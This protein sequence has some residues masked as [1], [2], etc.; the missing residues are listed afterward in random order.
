MIRIPFF[1]PNEAIIFPMV[2]EAL[3]SPDGLLCAGG[4][5]TTDNLL[6]AYQLGIFP[7]FA[8]DEPVL[9]WCPSERAIFYCD[10]INISKSMRKRL[11]K[12]DFRVTFDHAFIEVIN[13]CAAITK[14]RQDTWITDEMKVA[15]NLLYRQG[16]A[17]SVE[18]WQEDRLVGGLYGVFINNIFCG[19]SMFSKVSNTS[20]IALI[21]LTKLLNYH[22]CN[23]IDCQLMNPHLASLGAISLKRQQ[24]LTILIE[25][26]QK[27]DKLFNK[28]WGELTWCY[29]V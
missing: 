14:E 19:E 6:N 11:N 27:N 1:S 25:N 8:E 5:L 23:I 10:S 24:F 9:W 2:E 16:F 22:G 15:Y 7:W 3:D 21:Y 4:S 13:A 28:N 20:K 18:V 17:H 29:S 26:K 12:A